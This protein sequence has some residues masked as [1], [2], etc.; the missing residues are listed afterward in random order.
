MR[1]FGCGNSKLRMARAERRRSQRSLRIGGPRCTA[2]YR[3]RIQTGD[4]RRKGRVGVPRA[5]QPSNRATDP[6]R[7]T[8]FVDAGPTLAEA[9]AMAYLRGAEGGV[10]RAAKGADC[11]SAASWLRRFESC[12]PHHRNIQQLQTFARRPSAPR[13]LNNSASPSVRPIGVRFSI[14]L[15]WTRITHRGWGPPGR[16]LKRGRRSRPIPGDLWSIALARRAGAFCRHSTPAAGKLSLIIRVTVD[17]DGEARATRV[18]FAT[19]RQH[20][21]VSRPRTST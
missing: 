5:P 13:C 17:S 12:L 1:P 2:S 20:P 19:Q 11:K 3:R 16:L 8:P 6:R 7:P 14:Q 15:S 10:S 18:P 4:F 21:R 9:I